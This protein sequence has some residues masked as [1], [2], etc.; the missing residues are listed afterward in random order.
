MQPVLMQVGPFAIRWYGLMIALAC[1]IGLWVAGKEAERKGIGRR[2]AQDFFLY[3]L[4]GGLIGAHLYYMAFNGR[5]QLWDNPLS[6]FA[7][8]QGGLA[9]HGAILGGLLAAILFTRK[10][11]IPFLNR[12]QK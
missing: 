2:Q 12:V 7:I 5:E 8:W 9:I 1:F 11:K 3:A 10:H 6:F 4:P